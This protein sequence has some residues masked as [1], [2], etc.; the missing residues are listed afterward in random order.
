MTK[1]LHNFLFFFKLNGDV[2]GFDLILTLMKQHLTQIRHIWSSP[3]NNE[4]YDSVDI[5]QIKLERVKYQLN[6]IES[7]YYGDFTSMY[8]VIENILRIFKENCR[9]NVGFSPYLIRTGNVG[10][11][12]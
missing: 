10:S 6:V 2:G 4:F 9:E 1:G 7:C 12:K 8:I 3:R 11:P 5:L